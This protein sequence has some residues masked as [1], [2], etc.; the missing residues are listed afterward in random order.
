MSTTWWVTKKR[1]RRSNV[2]G[3]SSSMR[4]AGS[5]YS[6]VRIRETDR[7]SP[8]RRASRE[9][10]VDP[11]QPRPERR[12]VRPAL[13]R[14]GPPPIRADPASNRC[15]CWC[16]GWCCGR[17]PDPGSRLRFWLGP[18]PSRYGSPS[19]RAG[20][21]GSASSCT[22]EPLLRNRAR[23]AI[24]LDGLHDGVGASP[25]PASESILW[26][27]NSRQPACAAALSAPFP[28]GS[29]A[30][31]EFDRKWPENAY[32]LGDV[33]SASDRRDRGSSRSDGRWIDRGE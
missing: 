22:V 6:A 20:A 17:R 3:S 11:A 13:R 16:P 14:R 12:G 19:H 33:S 25:Q 15:M 32:R 31:P 1:G 29:I 24:D 4:P 23:T 30:Q 2:V 8:R 10:V 18:V 27:A 7:R 28:S 9:A 5:S 21:F 26:I